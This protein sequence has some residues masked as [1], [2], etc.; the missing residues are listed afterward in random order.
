MGLNNLK[1]IPE[2]FFFASPFTLELYSPYSC[3]ESDLHQIL[4]V[5]IRWL[6]TYCYKYLVKKFNIRTILMPYL[7]SSLFKDSY[8]FQWDYAS[9]ADL[10]KDCPAPVCCRELGMRSMFLLHADYH[11]RLLRNPSRYGQ[12]R[13]VFIPPPKQFQVLSLIVFYFGCFLAGFG[14]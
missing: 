11:P 12:A 8:G 1:P 14:F 10:Q 5:K 7:I 4:R 2:Y 9:S 6:K 13:S 3:E